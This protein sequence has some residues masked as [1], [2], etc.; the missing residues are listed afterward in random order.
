MLTDDEL[1]VVPFSKPSKGVILQIQI[2]FIEVKVLLNVFVFITWSI[3]PLV[4]LY[5]KVITSLSASETEPLSHCKSSIFVG[6]VSF[7]DADVNIGKLFT[8]DIFVEFWYIIPPILSLISTVKFIMACATV[9][10]AAFEHLSEVP[11]N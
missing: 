8:T 10:V 11:D 6:E 7:I 1:T 2:S 4:Q 9:I 3:P 5:N